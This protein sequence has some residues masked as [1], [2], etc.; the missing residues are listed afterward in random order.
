MT[1]FYLRG[2]VPAEVLTRYQK[3]YFNRPIREHIAPIKISQN[4]TF[5]SKVYPTDASAGIFTFNDKYGTPVVIATTEHTHLRLFA[6][7]GVRM[8]GRC[9]SCKD[10]FKTQVIGTPHE[11]E[12]LS[13][14]GSDNR[15]HI[16]HVYHI[17]GEFCSFE[18]ALYWLLLINKKTE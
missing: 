1:S 13:L 12:H 15:Y 18:C 6:K 14:L 4:A 2:I 9:D 8:G 7:N 5:V 3:G 16:Y 11:Y 10:D 17:T